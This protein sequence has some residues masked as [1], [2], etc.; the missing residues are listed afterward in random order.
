[1]EV[2]D[3]VGRVLQITRLGLLAPKPKPKPRPHVMAY[4]TQ[5]PER[6]RGLQVASWREEPEIVWQRHL[7]D[8][9]RSRRVPSGMR[10]LVIKFRR[11]RQTEDMM[12]EMLESRGIYFLEIVDLTGQLP[13]LEAEVFATAFTLN[14][15]RGTL[16]LTYYHPVPPIPGDDPDWEPVRP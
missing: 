13:G 11:S 2:L 14:L 12:E 8:W 6:R 15:D 16:E 3:D 9:R 10:S 5:P 7:V 4:F 1:M